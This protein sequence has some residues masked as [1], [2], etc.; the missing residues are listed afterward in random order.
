MEEAVGQPLVGRGVLGEEPDL[1][2]RI[3]GLGANRL[4]RV[5]GGA[6]R[7][8]GW[9]SPSPRPVEITHAPL[10]P[11]DVLDIAQRSG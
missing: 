3:A 4:E 7:I 8:G 10:G 2:E 9:F 11:E 5:N 6:I 1:E